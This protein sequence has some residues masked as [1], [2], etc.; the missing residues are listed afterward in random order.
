[1]SARAVLFD[2]DGTLADT[3]RDM[4]VVLNRLID[5]EDGQK[6]TYEEFC[7][8]LSQGARGI[9]R[10]A[11]GG[12]ADK[13]KEQ[14]LLARFLELYAA[15]LCVNTCL[16]PEVKTTLRELTRCGTI[17]GVVTNK[18]QVYAEPLLAQLGISPYAACQ[19]YGDTT[20]NKK[21]SPDPLIYAAKEIRH[22]PETCF[23]VG[24]SAHDVQAAST[25]GMQ[26]V[27]AT[28]GYGRKS[29]DENNSP[30]CRLLHHF[31]ELPQLLSSWEQN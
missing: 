27:F 23:Y 24:D 30:D 20:P 29:F 25:A 7:R 28:Y 31:G 10:F 14:R 8:H 5:E 15:N 16:F 26:P 13:T 17:W 3:A 21:P 22:K 18:N 1:M 2:L 19:V 12:Q 4:A 9:V 6:I 11:F